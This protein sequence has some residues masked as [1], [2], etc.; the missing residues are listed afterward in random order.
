VYICT[1]CQDSSVNIVTRQGQGIFLF[2]TASTLVLEPHPQASIRWVTGA[3]FLGVKW[4]TARLH[5]V[6]RLRMLRVIPPLP[7]TSSWCGA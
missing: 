5:I 6:L 2:A 1:G 3:F 4:L 7:H